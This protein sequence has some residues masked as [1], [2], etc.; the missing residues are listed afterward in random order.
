MLKLDVQ[1][2]ATSLLVELEQRGLV[3]K[4]D[5]HDDVERHW[6]VG[7]AKRPGVLEITD[8]GSF[9]EIKVTAL[10]DGGWAS[11]LARELAGTG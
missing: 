8:H 7:Y 5:T 4:L 2:T 10:R 3:I 9:C 1:R 11:D 6:H